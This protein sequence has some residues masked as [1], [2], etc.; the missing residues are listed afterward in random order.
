MY[1]IQYS[2]TVFLAWQL[3]RIKQNYLEIY[4]EHILVLHDFAFSISMEAQAFYSYEW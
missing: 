3:V 1:C 4:I 2:I